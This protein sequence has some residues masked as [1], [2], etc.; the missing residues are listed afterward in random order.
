MSTK[1]PEFAKRFK[2]IIVREGINDSP[3]HLS[4]LLGVS[5]VMIWSYK[6]GKKLPRMAM[7]IK[8]ADTFNTTVEWLLQG[9]GRAIREPVAEYDT[10]SGNTAIAKEL[11][12]CVKS[13][14]ASEQE[15]ALHCYESGCYFDLALY[16]FYCTTF[17][18]GGCSNSYCREYCT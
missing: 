15:E 6:N 1:H 14:N 13:L 5:E 2:Q 18:T 4:K 7:A 11:M 12:T 3:K 17:Q 9:T 10:T 16:C 8:I